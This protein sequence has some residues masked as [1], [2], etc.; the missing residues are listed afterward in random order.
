MKSS[1]TLT[2]ILFKHGHL[3]R[4]MVVRD[5][6]Q[7]YKGSM[8]GVVWSLITPL[9]MLGVY[10]IVFSQIFSARWSANAEQ[11]TTQVAL[12]LFSGL[13]VHSML[14]ECLGR[15]PTVILQQS[16]LVTKVV[17]PLEILPLV[18]WC[19]SL[20]NFCMSLFVLLGGLLIFNGGVAWTVLYLPVV[21]LPLW[22]LMLGF[23]WFLASLGVFLRDI[24]QIIGL[25][26]TVLLFLSPVFYPTESLPEAWRQYVYFNPLAF[27]IEQVREV[28]LWGHLPA[29]RGIMWHSFVGFIIMI[30]GF[31]WFQRT[32]KA[33]ADVL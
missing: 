10:T 4:Q 7:R 8:L 3:C 6:Q 24:G 12:I 1:M 9:M 29:W 14:A 25:V 21:L 22:M 31:N 27:A 30:L 28:V 11:P 2:N 20:F 23:T 26:M 13:M 15:A 5:I 33:F 16:S 17:F 18:T 32:R 19:S